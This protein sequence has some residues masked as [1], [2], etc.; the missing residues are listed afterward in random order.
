MRGAKSE[1]IFDTSGLNA[2]A[3]DPS[4][5]AIIKSLGLGFIV[6]LSETSIAE[7]AAT[8]DS[9]RRNRLLDVC[10]HMVYAGECIRPYNLIIEQLTQA[11]AKDGARFNWE[12]LSV[13][14]PELEE[15]LAR[16]DFLG[17]DEIA[18]E[19]LEDFKAHSKEFEAIYKAARPAFDKLFEPADA[20][21]PP[22][23][24]LIAALK[25]PGGA[26]W[27]Q[28]AGMYKRGC[29][30]EIDEA[31]IRQFIA[32][33]PPF[34]AVL[35]SLCIAQ[36]NWCI[37]D[38]RAQSLYRAGRLDL[39]SAVYLP[40]C[41]RFVTNDPGQCEALKVAA[42]EANLTVDVSTYAEFSQAFLVAAEAVGR[43]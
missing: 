41:D 30:R 28:G 5:P 24:G 25:I 35:L 32:T 36:F 23:S 22:V 11:H 39:F 2:L 6:R 27:K 40:Y 21:R 3:D 16:R 19:I 14:G 38:I 34:H 12:T 7:I 37:R 20:E 4:S 31:G 29:G 1:L 42:R 17:K 13:R 43:P 9:A 33:C 10:R 18:E 26:F 15:E 8:R